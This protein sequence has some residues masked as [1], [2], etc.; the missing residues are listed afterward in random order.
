[1]FTP[2]IVVEH[3]A[4]SQDGRP[5]TVVGTCAAASPA[6]R[7]AGAPRSSRPSSPV[8]ST[9]SAPV[10][11]RGNRVGRAGAAHGASISESHGGQSARRRAR[12]P[13]LESVG[14]ISSPYSSPRN[15]RASPREVT[16]L[17]SSIPSRATS[18][19]IAAL[20][21]GRHPP[22]RRSRGRPCIVVSWPGD[23]SPEHFC[24]GASL[25]NPARP[26][27]NASRNAGHETSE[28]SRK[29]PRSSTDSGLRLVRNFRRVVTE[30]RCCR[31]PVHHRLIAINARTVPSRAL[32]PTSQSTRRRCDG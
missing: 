18:T 8:T 7:W 20:G 9:S 13:P 24:G 5:P 15:R 28:P 32:T 2:H 11:R 29:L 21:R 14:A 4:C 22:P 17:S 12:P 3:T 19:S 31:P 30:R 25:R 23:A 26:G 10:P 16:A 1:M 6:H 27:L